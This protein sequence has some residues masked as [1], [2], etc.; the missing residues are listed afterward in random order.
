MQWP[1]SYLKFWDYYSK[2]VHVVVWKIF[3]MLRC[4]LQNRSLLHPSEKKRKKRRKILQLA[5]PVAHSAPR[6]C[7]TAR[8]GLGSA[9]PPPLS[10]SLFPPP[11]R[12]PLLLS[13]SPPPKPGPAGTQKDA[14]RRHHP[15]RNQGATYR[16]CQHQVLHAVRQCLCS[17]V[18]WYEQ[19]EIG[20]FGYFFFWGRNFGYVLSAGRHIS[21]CLVD[22]ICGITKFASSWCV[23][24]NSKLKRGYSGSVLSLVVRF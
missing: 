7:P 10:H 20:N 4:G 3:C 19:S 15:S 18:S 21:C 5:T 22:N 23:S 1:F 8:V 17:F 16:S 24:T 11:Q 9:P 14:R 2:L 13:P 12:L 6:T